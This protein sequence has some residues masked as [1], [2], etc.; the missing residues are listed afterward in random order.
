MPICWPPSHECFGFVPFQINPHFTP[1]RSYHVVDGKIE[2]YAG[3]TRLNRLEEYHEMNDL[4]VLALREGAILRVEGDAA[5][6]KGPGTA[7]LLRKGEP[8]QDLPAESDL[9]HLLAG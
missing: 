2:P 6:L 7:L 8:A 5:A 3:E 4:P 1:G 9:S